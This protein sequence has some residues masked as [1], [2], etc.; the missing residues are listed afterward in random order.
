VGHFLN[1]ACFYAALTDE[2]P[3]SKLPRGPE[4]AL[5]EFGWVNRLE[6][7]CY[8]EAMLGTIGGGHFPSGVDT[9]LYEGEGRLAIGKSATLQGAREHGQPVSG[10]Y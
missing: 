9:V 6:P 2:S 8:A 10:A 7:G 5:N 3:A 4:W 1:L